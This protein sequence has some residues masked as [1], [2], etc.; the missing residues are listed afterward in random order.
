MQPLQAKVYISAQQILTKQ[1]FWLVFYTVWLAGIEP[2]WAC[3][4]R[5]IQ[6]YTN[7]IVPPMHAAEVYKN[8]TTN[9]LVV[10]SYCLVCRNGWNKHTCVEQEWIYQ[11]YATMI[12]PPLHTCRSAQEVPK[13][14]S[15]NSSNCFCCFI[16]LFG[17][18]YYTEYR[19]NHY[20]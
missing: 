19:Q 6:S 5:Q 16:I 3:M 14:F 17:W 4:H 18:L 13:T 7:M 2:A 12:L 15:H 1:Q 9:S 20:M 8:C 11:W 10:V